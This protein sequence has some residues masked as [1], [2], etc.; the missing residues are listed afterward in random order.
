LTAQYL[1]YEVIIITSTLATHNT[2]HMGVGKFWISGI[3][4]EHLPKRGQDTPMTRMYHHAIFTPIGATVAKISVSK[5]R[6][7]T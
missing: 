3:P 5:N 4:W 1:V 7:Q 6:K 2:R